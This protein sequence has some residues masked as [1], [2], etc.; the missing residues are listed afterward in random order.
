MASDGGI[1]WIAADTGKEF[2]SAQILMEMMTELIKDK[3]ACDEIRAAAICYDARTV[4]P[5]GAVKIDVIS[6]NLECLLGESI[7]VFL[8]YEKRENGEIRYGEMFAA[9]KTR[10]FFSNSSTA[11]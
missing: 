3:A 10:Q 6:F 7:S 4:P 2:P 11:D 8:P 1:Q 9:E 5:G